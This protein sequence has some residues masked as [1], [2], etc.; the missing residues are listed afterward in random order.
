MYLWKLQIACRYFNTVPIDGDRHQNKFYFV[1]ILQKQYLGFETIVSKNS[2]YTKLQVQYLGLETIV[3]DISK[4]TCSK[5]ELGNS[6]IH[7]YPGT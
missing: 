7:F 4:N 2:K 5:I 6:S 3:S 1:T